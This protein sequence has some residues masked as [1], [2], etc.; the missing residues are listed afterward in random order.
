MTAKWPGCRAWVAAALSAGLAIVGVPAVK[1][2]GESLPASFRPGDVRPRLASPLPVGHQVLPAAVAMNSAAA[3]AAGAGA[4]AR[5]Q[6]ERA[7]APNGTGGQIQ[8]PQGPTSGSVAAIRQPARRGKPRPTMFLPGWR[9]LLE[10]RWRARLATVTELSVAYHNV[11]DR[12]RRGGRDSSQAESPELR[13]LMRQTVAA[14]QALADTED[15]L[16]RLSAGRFG[17]CEQCAAM[18]NASQL[19]RHPEERYCAHCTQVPPERETLDGPA[20]VVRGEPPPP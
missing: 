17:H 12:M 2:A 9:L 10:H 8:L 1:R 14:R 3:A 5:R 13:R 11:A 4:P 18:I 6:A 15:A 16:A 20:M 19:A 7:L